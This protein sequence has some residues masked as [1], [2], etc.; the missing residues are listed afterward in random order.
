[1]TI[2]LGVKLKLYPNKEQKQTIEQTFG[3]SRFVWNQFKNMQENRYNAMIDDYN[4][5]KEQDKKH[6]DK[7]INPIYIEDYDMQKLLTE[8]KKENS[9]LHLSDATVLQKTLSNLDRAYKNFFTKPDQFE[10]PKFKSRK[11]RNQSFTG[12]ANKRKSGKTSVYVAGP[13]YVYVP[14]LGFI[15]TSKTTRINGQIKEYTITRESFGAYYI[16]FQIEEPNRELLVKTKQ[17]MGGDLGLTHLLT[18]SNGLK[19]PKF[20]PGQTLALSL[21]AQSKASKSM[22]R[23]SKILNTKELIYLI[24]TGVFDENKYDASDLF[25]FK[26][27]EKRMKKSAKAQRKIANKRHDY[28]HKLTTAL[29]NAYDVIVLEDLKVKNMLKN[30]KLAKAISNA[31]KKIDTTNAAITQGEKT[32][33]LNVK[34]LKT[35]SKGTLNLS[36]DQVK[37]CFDAVDIVNSGDTIDH[38]EYGTKTTYNDYLGDQIGK[39]SQK[40]LRIALKPNEHCP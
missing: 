3:N 14:K 31:S 40:V 32:I 22:N 5:Y 25:D 2:L 33:Q 28:L 26:N 21:K 7:I 10:K 8:L 27:H 9:W 29:V 23:N 19:F 16:S 35:I 30:H 1:M 11:H 38:L 37:H 20:S 15:K 36:N 34:D 13:R 4:S 6:G 17:L 24:E 39:T 18:L 12:R